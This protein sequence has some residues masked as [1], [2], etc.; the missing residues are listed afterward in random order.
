MGDRCCNRLKMLVLLMVFFNFPLSF[1]AM[2][3]ACDLK[4]LGD[5]SELK[6]STIRVPDK[7]VSMS[8]QI[9]VEM[10]FCTT[11]V[12]GGTPS[13]FFLIDHS[14]SM[15]GPQGKDRLGR[16]F[17]VAQALI[18]TLRKIFPKA[19]VGIGAFK[20]Y[21]Y[22]DPVDNPRFVKAPG[23]DTG[24]YL[25]F[26]RFD[27]SYAPDGKLGYQITREMLDTVMVNGTANLKYTPSNLAVNGSGTNI[28]CGI[29]AVK[30]AFQSAKYSKD[31]RFVILQIQVQRTG[32][33]IP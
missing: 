28:N 12:I 9:K 26:F 33:S 18:D 24:A 25:P 16:R 4:Y 7:V 3:D 6:D 2:K 19:E 20:I 27:S 1:A 21:L 23:N 17:T 31:R 5:I 10:P 32:A 15:G 14:T 22:F 8:A 13:I 30:H 29:D 11:S